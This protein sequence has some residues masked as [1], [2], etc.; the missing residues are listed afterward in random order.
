ML[1]ET[2]LGLEHM[3]A[4]GLIHRDIKVENIMLDGAGHVKLIDFGLS[5][6][7][8]GYEEPVSP[9][10]SLIYMAPEVGHSVLPKARLPRFLLSSSVSL[11]FFLM[12][13]IRKKKNLARRRLVSCPLPPSAVLGRWCATTW[14]AGTPTGG[15]SACSPTSFSLAGRP[16]HL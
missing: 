5:C 14:A 2:V 4:H 8:R 10:G 13:K 7:L 6:E 11:F 3:H 9:T 12:K 15:P 16:G 1:S